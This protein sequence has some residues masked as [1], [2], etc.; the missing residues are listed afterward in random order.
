MQQPYREKVRPSKPWN[1]IPQ[2][3]NSVRI[4]MQNQS[5]ENFLDY[6]PVRLH[7]L[8]SR[9]WMPERPGQTSLAQMIHQAKKQNQD[10]LSLETFKFILE[11]VPSVKSIEFSGEEDPLNLPELFAMLKHAQEF[12][13][14][15]TRL[16]TNGIAMS[17]YVEQLV[18]SPLSEI[19]VT[20]DAH[21]PSSFRL[22]T[23]RD[24]KL[25]PMVRNAIQKLVALRNR[26]GSQLKV[27][28]RLMVDRQ[29]VSALPEMITFA[30]EELDVDFLTIQN[31]GGVFPEQLVG[32]TIFQTQS[33]LVQ[34]I[35]KTQEE[36]K[37]AYPKLKIE[38]P[39]IP[40]SVEQQKNASGSCREPYKTVT[41]DQDCNVSPCSRLMYAGGGSAKIWDYN[42]WNNEKYQWLRSVHMTQEAD[43]GKCQPLPL[44]CQF[45]PK[46]TLKIR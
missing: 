18:A 36:A 37:K 1:K 16:I 33:N 6:D 21:R 9:R 2:I 40:P 43:S 45:C 23:G 4:Q 7:I 8:T 44:L 41:V 10:P 5:D 32:K 34:I 26:E 20:L 28:V 42:F 38:W 11:Q 24:S 46:N 35:E 13:G 29:S 27:G 14:A 30:A 25:F 12:L 3:I 39:V 15:E 17:L 19:T 22:V 31:A